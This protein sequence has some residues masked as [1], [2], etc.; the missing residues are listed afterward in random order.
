MKLR[1]QFG[2]RGLA[3]GI[4]FPDLQDFRGGKPCTPV[5][6]ASGISPFGYAIRVIIGLRTEPKMSGIHAGGIVAAGTVVED[7]QT[8]R[9]GADMKL[10]GDTACCPARCSSSGKIDPYESIAA[11]VLDSGPEPAGVGFGDVLPKPSFGR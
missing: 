3:C 8:V 5:A 1:H 4:E 6:F 11:L 2:T 7:V 10:P 9:D